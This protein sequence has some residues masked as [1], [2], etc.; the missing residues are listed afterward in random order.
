L[1]TGFESRVE[2]LLDAH[3]PEDLAKMVCQLQEHLLKLA[4]VNEQLSGALVQA[5][6]ALR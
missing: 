5:S 6:F 2:A 3:K 4:M 1:S